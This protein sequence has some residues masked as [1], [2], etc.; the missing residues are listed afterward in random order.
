MDRS[1]YVFAQIFAPL[2]LRQ[3]DIEDPYNFKVPIYT[4]WGMLAALLIINVFIPESP[5]EFDNNKHSHLRL[6]KA[7]VARPEGQG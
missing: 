1:W 5:C 3:L 2:A 4:Q 7:R 6:T